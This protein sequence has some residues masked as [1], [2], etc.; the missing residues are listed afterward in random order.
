MN[1]KLLRRYIVIAA[2]ATF[3]MF[4]IWTLTLVF[5][6]E[7]PGDYYTREGDIRLGESK[8]DEAMESF[9]KALE[10]E[11]NHRG[12]LMGRALVY[13][14]TSKTAEAVGE[15]THLIKFL[16]RTLEDDDR[17]GWG[18]LASAYAN[19]GIIHDRHGRY[20]KALADYVKALK[21]DEGALSGPSLFDKILYG[22]SQPSTVRK[23]AVY[24]NQQL[25][26]PPGQR[27]LRMPEVDAEQRMYKPCGGVGAGARP[28]QGVRN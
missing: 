27:L 24:L 9:N 15:L 11:P 10:E 2:I 23:R 22:T 26:L 4:S 25:A 19:R 16:E 18:T 12:A 17:T 28:R 7:A 6:N 3:A 20:K 13:I 8:Y 5:F 21:T 14:Q 1:P